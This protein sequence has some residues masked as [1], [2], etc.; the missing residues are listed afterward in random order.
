MGPYKYEKFN[1][2]DCY[3]NYDSNGNHF[4]L[5]YAQYTKIIKT[6]L[7]IYFYEVF[8]LSYP[9]YFLFGGKII[10]NRI[11]GKVVRSKLKSQNNELISLNDSVGFLWYDRP[12]K[13]FKEFTFKKLVGKTGS[14]QKI[15]REWMQ[16]NDVGILPTLTELNI[17]GIKN[18]YFRNL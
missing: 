7:V 12:F 17:K 18:D 3:K 10:K 1:T 6:F 4:S 9:I 8:F 2:N 14:L 15:Q 11:P 5:T 16:C 13:K